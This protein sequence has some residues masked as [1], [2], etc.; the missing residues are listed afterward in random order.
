LMVVTFTVVALLVLVAGV[1]TSSVK[2]LTTGMGFCPTAPLLQWVRATVL[3]RAVV[4]VG[5]TCGH[6]F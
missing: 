2:G 1:V 6:V 4:V 5:R 3:V